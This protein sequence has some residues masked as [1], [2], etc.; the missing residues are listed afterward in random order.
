MNRKKV[1]PDIL[2]FVAFVVRSRCLLWCTFCHNEHHQRTTGTTKVA[3]CKNVSV[4]EKILLKRSHLKKIIIILLLVTAYSASAQVKLPQIIRDSMILQRDEKIKVWGWAS[5]SEKVNILFK[6]KTYK[7]KADNK[8]KWMI[9]LP[10]TPAGGPYNIDITASNKITIKDILFGDVWF[11]SG[12]SNMVHQLN[13]HDVTY[14]KDIAEANFPQI[15]QFWIPTLTS[16]QGPLINLPTGHWKPAVGEDVRPFSAVAYF[17]AKKIHEKYRIPVGIINASVGGAPIEAW[18]SEEGLKEFA[19]V[20][21]TI[22]KNKD[23]AYINSLNRR[24][25]TPAPNRPVQP[26]DAGMSSAIKWYDTA[27]VPKGWHNINIPGFW[28]DQGLKDFKYQPVW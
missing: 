14:A 10:P 7:T 24:T 4:H 22:E 13:I 16:L 21:T 23:T 28:E 15:R 25:T 8:G 11:F 6:G 2:D 18:I 1:K 20:V 3:Y 26:P 12:Q 17:F 27:Y 9:S 19:S 5:A